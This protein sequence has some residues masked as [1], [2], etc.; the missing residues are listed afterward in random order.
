M[1]T[2]PQPD[3]GNVAR[4]MRSAVT[5]DGGN[6]I[7][8]AQPAS[9]PTIAAYCA[10]TSNPCVTAWPDAN[11]PAAWC[12]GTRTFDILPEASPCPSGDHL[13][14]LS[15][16]TA[17]GN[18]SFIYRGT[19]LIGII[20]FPDDTSTGICLAGDPTLGQADIANCPPNNTVAV[21]NNGTIQ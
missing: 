18:K 16:S 12:S 4:D 13:V 3:L 15:N 20:G 11:D 7:D 6:T 19:V 5:P 9:C 1:T 10:D 21:C 14:V 17:F 8:M 2:D